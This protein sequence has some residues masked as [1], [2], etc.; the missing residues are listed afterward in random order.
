M[1]A[2]NQ[3]NV[4]TSAKALLPQHLNYVVNLKANSKSLGE[5]VTRLREQ[6]FTA[7][8]GAKL[9]IIGVSAYLHSQGVRFHYTKEEREKARARKNPD[10]LRLKRKYTKRANVAPPETASSSFK[11]N[12]AKVLEIGGSDEGLC[13]RLVSA[14]VADGI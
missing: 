5:V 7:P 11:S 8:T 6:G 4:A 1:N 10:S 2:E 14:L 3:K 12:L 13:K 9:G